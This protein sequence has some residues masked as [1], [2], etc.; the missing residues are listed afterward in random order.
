MHIL[1]KIYWDLD[2][3]SFTVKTTWWPWNQV[4]SNIL[5]IFV[6]NL[7]SP[8]SYV[9]ILLPSFEYATLEFSPGTL[10]ECYLYTSNVNYLVMCKNLKIYINDVKLRQVACYVSTIQESNKLLTNKNIKQRRTVSHKN[11][12]FTE[13]LNQ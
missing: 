13:T 9:M 3:R 5:L 6:I 8:I 12:N 7:V 11:A 10:M 4:G 2:W 1:G